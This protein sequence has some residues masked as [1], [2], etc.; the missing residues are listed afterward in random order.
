MTA[1][2]TSSGARRFVTVLALIAL[3]VL[4][5][6]TFVDL[7]T[8]ATGTWMGGVESPRRGAGGT[9]SRAGSAASESSDR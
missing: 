5:R 3:G 2:P 6:F 1:E 7:L 9:T 8:K 4:M